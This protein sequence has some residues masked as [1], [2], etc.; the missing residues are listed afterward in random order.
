MAKKVEEIKDTRLSPTD[1]NGYPKWFDVSYPVEMNDGT[2]HD[3]LLGGRIRRDEAGKWEVDSVKGSTQAAG[4]ISDILRSPIE[5]GKVHEH[6][7]KE[8]EK[9]YII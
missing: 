9:N 4:L 5:C 8:L 3:V 7:R 2:T 1:E 6:I